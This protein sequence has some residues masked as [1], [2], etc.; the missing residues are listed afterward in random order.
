[1]EEGFK[2]VAN[3]LKFQSVLTQ[4]LVT[5]CQNM[6]HKLKDLGVTAVRERAP[7]DDYSNSLHTQQHKNPNYLKKL[8]DWT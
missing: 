6:L 7:T 5:R 1:M 8:D 2:T 4:S 3:L